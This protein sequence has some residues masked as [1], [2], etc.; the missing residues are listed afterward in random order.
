MTIAMHE[1]EESRGVAA[2]LARGVAVGAEDENRPAQTLLTW[3]AISQA[4]ELARV[5]RYSEADQ[6]L[7]ELKTGDASAAVLDL[8]ARIHAQQ[9]RLSA[10]EAFWT[11]ALHLDPANLAYNEALRRISRM[12]RRRLHALRPLLWTLAAVLCVALAV[13]IIEQ[14]LARQFSAALVQ[15]P[16]ISQAAQTEQST[17]TQTEQSADAAQGVRA[18]AR[19]AEQRDAPALDIDVRGVRSSIDGDETV[20]VFESGLFVRATEL[21]PEGKSVLNALAGQIAPYAGRVSVNVEGHTSSLPV[22]KGHTFR[23]NAAL[24]M[25]RAVTVVDYLRGAASLPPEMFS[26]SSAGESRPPHTNPETDAAAL[27]QTVVL[28]VSGFERQRGRR[29]GEE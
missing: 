14:R 8:R 6:L 20:L 2:A 18:Q 12:Q 25:Q 24:G 19:R 28:R 15:Q 1:R 5:G 17:T 26:V 29:S 3:L 22:T 21:T 10:A 23:D 16:H 4:S 13:Y 11:R 9:G 7:S 27:N